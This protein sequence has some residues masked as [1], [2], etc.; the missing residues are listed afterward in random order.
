MKELSVQLK[1]NALYPLSQ[2]D[3]EILR[4]YKQNQILRC[5]LQGA[6]KPRSLIQL[7]LYWALCQVVADNTENKLWNTK[8]K[9]D[10]QC[11]VKQH[12]VDPD[13][14]AIQPDGTVVFSYRSIAFINLGHIEACRYF[15]RAF[16][17]MADFLGVDIDT[18]INMGSES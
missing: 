7:R 6:R 5:K 3:L 4:N 13:I 10:F 11:R 15:D 18:L 8:E 17:I 2:E 14:V 1:S 16:E 12:F 9:V